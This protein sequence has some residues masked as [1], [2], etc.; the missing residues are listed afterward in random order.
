VPLSQSDRRVTINGISNDSKNEHE[1]ELVDKKTSH[2]SMNEASVI[3]AAIQEHRALLGLVDPAEQVS[4]VE[5]DGKRKMLPTRPALFRVF[6][7]RTR[8]QGW[9]GAGCGEN[10]ESVERKAALAGTRF[11]VV[12]LCEIKSHFVTIDS[13]VL[14]GILKEIS[15]GLD[16]RNKE[17]TGENRDTYW[18]HVFDGKRLNTSQKRYSEVS[19]K[20]NE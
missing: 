17:F 9:D 1:I 3:R 5:K 10:A 6:G 13:R 7:P 15:S 18:T 16:V 4:E 11:E 2:R 12:R 19:S 8:T 20:L 14:Y